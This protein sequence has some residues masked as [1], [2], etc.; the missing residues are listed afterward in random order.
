MRTRCRAKG[1][2]AEEKK[3]ESG[4]QT[5]HEEAEPKWAK[6]KTEG[7]QRRKMIAQCRAQ[8]FGRRG[9]GESRGGGGG[10]GDKEAQVCVLA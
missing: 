4:E 1:K 9:R 10:D 3:E 7:G 8:F 2:I 6:G 5:F